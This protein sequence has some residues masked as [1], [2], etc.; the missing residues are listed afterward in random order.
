MLSIRQLRDKFELWMGLW[1]GMKRFVRP[2]SLPVGARNPYAVYR[3]RHHDNPF[4]D[5][6]PVQVRKK[7]HGLGESKLEYW[8]LFD[9][10]WGSCLFC[11]KTIDAS[12]GKG[13]IEANPDSVKK[14]NPVSTPPSDTG[15]D[16]SLAGAPGNYADCELSLGKA[17]WSVKPGIPPTD[18]TSL[19]WPWFDYP[20]NPNYPNFP[21]LVSPGFEDPMQGPVLD[22]YLLASLSAIAWNCA[23]NK[24]R[25]KLVV[26]PVNPVQFLTTSN[27]YINIGPPGTQVDTDYS[28]PVDLSLPKP[29]AIGATT[30]SGNSS[31]VPY[32]EKAFARYLEYTKILPASAETSHPDICR[33]PCGN[34]GETLRA[35]M[36]RSSSYLYAHNMEGKAR[37]SD[38]RNADL[39]WN[40]LR[41]SCCELPFLEPVISQ[42]PPVVCDYTLWNAWK[43][44]F[45]VVARTNCT[46]DP[47]VTK[48]GSPPL[49][50]APSG[51]GADYTDDLILASH[52]YS[53]LGLHKR[54]PPGET[55]VKRYVILRNPYNENWGFIKD[56]T[57]YHLSEGPLIFNSIKNNA[58]VKYSRNLFET[59]NGAQLPINGVFA[60]QIEDFVKWFAEFN[61]VVA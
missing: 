28:L 29:A 16:E 1:P 9:P 60:L 53:L 21:D 38:L 3:A 14:I 55:E 45:P 56:K 49:C 36:K 59:R 18:P 35:L 43:T 19:Y 33:I 27:T 6:N 57:N 31:W 17:T 22:C 61:W 7:L 30:K 13:T 25:S 15:S 4:Y 47:L 37:D 26:D 24:T 39:V 34:P 11:K 20:Y 48:N 54:I 44:R 52:A 42:G 23:V 12:W 32:Y 10:M 2:P 51:S 58:Q 40:K 46:G 50:A 8:Q 5:L 41:D